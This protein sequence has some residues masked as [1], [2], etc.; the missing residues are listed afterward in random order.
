MMLMM[1]NS[2][3][4]EKAFKAQLDG[5]QEEIK[6]VVGGYAQLSSWKMVNHLTRTGCRFIPQCGS[7]VKKNFWKK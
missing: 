6:Y 2:Y 7:L 1:L 5:Q 4:S 3:E